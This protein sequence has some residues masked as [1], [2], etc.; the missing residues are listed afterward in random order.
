MSAQPQT[1]LTPEEY[2]AIE[3]DAAAKSQYWDGRMFAMAG[4]SHQHN[5]IQINLAAELRNVLKTSTCEPAGP[6]LRLWVSARGMYTYPDVMVL[7]RQPEYLDERRDTVSN[8]AVI[9]EVLSRSTEAYDRGAK[10]AG[11]R[12]L[13]SLQEYVLVAQTEARVERFRRM[14]GDRW[15]LTEL[16]GIEG[17]LQ[18]ESV[19]CLI[20]MAEIYSRVEFSGQ[21]DI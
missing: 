18:L 12:T 8:P 19:P 13:P 3:R 9:L 11:Y 15:I 17:S 6:D 20:P 2:L 4:G 7:S 1:F 5:R 14:S 10:F 16:T 21:P